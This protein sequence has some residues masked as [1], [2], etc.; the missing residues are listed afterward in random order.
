MCSQ[1]SEFHVHLLKS[2]DD[3][4][5]RQLIREE[6]TEIKLRKLVTELREQLLLAHM[7]LERS[8]QVAGAAGLRG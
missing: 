8:K 1:D 7:E 6:H 3:R 2:K 4:M 5:A